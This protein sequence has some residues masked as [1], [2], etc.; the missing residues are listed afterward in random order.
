M[1]AALII[2]APYITA[3][4]AVYGAYSANAA[5]KEAAKGRAAQARAQAFEAKRRKRIDDIAASRSRR[6]AARGHRRDIAVAQ[7]KAQASSSASTGFSGLLASIGS[8]Y[9]SALQESRSRDSL[10]GEIS[11]FNQSQTSFASAAFGNAASRS[12][13]ANAAAGLNTAVSIFKE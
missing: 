6:E 1:A 11:V 12:G 5:G 2:A 13:R 7:N 8:Q 3:A 4:T 10:L 9:T